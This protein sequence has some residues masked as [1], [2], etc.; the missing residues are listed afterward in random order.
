MIAITKAIMVTK[1]AAPMQAPRMRRVFWSVRS[2]FTKVTPCSSRAVRRANVC[3]TSSCS[4]GPFS[5]WSSVQKPIASSKSA[6]RLR[7]RSSCWLMPSASVRCPSSISRISAS[8]TSS[9]R[10]SLMRRRR[11][12]SA[13]E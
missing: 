13:C 8:G 6:R 7:R 5:C 1:R 3:S 4:R 11:S 9:L 12:T 10:S 2:M